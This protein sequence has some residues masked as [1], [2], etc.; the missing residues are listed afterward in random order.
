M[1]NLQFRK[2]GGGGTAS[3][4]CPVL[5]ADIPVPS[6]ESGVYTRGFNHRE[7][8]LF[9]FRKVVWWEDEGGI[10]GLV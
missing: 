8:S 9:S 4:S 6:S 2:Q 7:E 5:Q 3:D 10:T 1:Q